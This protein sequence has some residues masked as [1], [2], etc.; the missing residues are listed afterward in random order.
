M[1]WKKVLPM[2]EKMAFFLRVKAGERSFRAGCQSFGISRRTGYKWWQ[3]SQAAGLAGL[4][5][6]SH[7]PRSCPHA[8]D[9]RW[10]ERV[11]ALRLRHP[12]WGPR[13]LRVKLG[14][15]YGA[16]AVPA[17]STLGHQLQLRG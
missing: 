7:R 14:E 5:E 3:R 16:Q 2:E 11:V 12:N 1:P 13:K 17:A 6:R 9:P 4:A 15:R 8:S 10:I